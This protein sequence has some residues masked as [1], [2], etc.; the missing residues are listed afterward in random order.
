M[1]DGKVT[2][3]F[4]TDYEHGGTN[5]PRN[6]LPIH[7]AC[8]PVQPETPEPAIPELELDL[9]APPPVVGAIELTGRIDRG[10]D[11]VVGEWLE[12]CGTRPPD[13]VIARVGKQ[14]RKLI[15]EGMVPADIS[16]GLAAWQAKGLDPAAIPSMVNAAMNGDNGS[17]TDRRVAAGMRLA[18]EYRDRGR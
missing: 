1:E 12:Q 10:A 17:T 11:T 18:Q 15:G 16:A 13:S 4:G 3:A 8:V 5:H 9:P 2:L 14:V 6:I 7:P